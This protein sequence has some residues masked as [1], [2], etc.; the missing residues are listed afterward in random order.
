MLRSDW[1]RPKPATLTTIV[2]ITKYKNPRSKF[3]SERIVMEKGITYQTCY[4]LTLYLLLLL[5]GVNDRFW[6]SEVQAPESDQVEM[7]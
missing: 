7:Y 2:F 6:M 5:F 3:P 1:L 4:S